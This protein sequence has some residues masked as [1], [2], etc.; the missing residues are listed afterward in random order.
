MVVKS[1]T[2]SLCD[3]CF[4]LLIDLMHMY[5]KITRENCSSKGNV[6]IQDGSLYCHNLPHLGS[7]LFSVTVFYVV[8]LEIP[9]GV[10]QSYTSQISV[11]GRKSDSSDTSLQKGTKAE[12]KIMFFSQPVIAMLIHI[13]VLDL[14]FKLLYGISHTH[15]IMIFLHIPQMV[16][17]TKIYTYK[18]I[19]TFLIQFI[20]CL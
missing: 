12:Y 6:V 11:S 1:L 2:L 7:Q 4:S 17:H 16:L 20:K 9:S 5:F 19:F 18:S 15:C 3:I 10:S 8:T 14:K 13:I